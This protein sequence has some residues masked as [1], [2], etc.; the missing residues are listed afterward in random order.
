MSLILRPQVSFSRGNDN[1]S[2]Q[3]AVAGDANAGFPSRRRHQVADDVLVRGRKICGILV[4]AAIEGDRLQYLNGH[5]SEHRTTASFR[6]RSLTAR[7][8][9][10]WK[11]GGRSSGDFAPVMLP[12]LDHWYA[13]LCHRP[14]Q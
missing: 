8:R 13:F 3:F 6:S 2:R 7:L 11:T 4:E 1:P 10:S 12:R 5:R 14:T 9:F